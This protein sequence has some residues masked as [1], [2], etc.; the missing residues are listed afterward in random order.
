MNVDGLF[1]CTVVFKDNYESQAKVIVNQGGTSSSKTYSIMQTLILRAIYN[2][3]LVITVTGESIPN[4]KK[5][6]YRD[7]ETIY[8]RSSYMNKQVTAWN[9]TDR[10]IYF[11]SGSIIEFV[12][13]LDEQS[14]KNGKRDLLF[15]NEGQ[16]I[17]W[18]IFFQ[19]AIRTR[20]QIF[21]DY[22]PTVP[23]WVHDKLIG[24][25]PETNDLTAVVQLII[26]DHRH[27]TF[28]SDD[29][30]RKIEGIK[31]KELWRVYARGLT[32]NLTGLIF[33]DWKE[34]PDKDYPWDTEKFGGLDFGYTN[35]PTAGVRIAR[36]GESIYLH[37][38]CYTPGLAPI[39]MKQIFTAEGFTEE[40]NIYCEH[41]PDNIR[42]LRLL[43]IRAIAAR[44]GQGSVNSG[45]IKLKEYKV[46]YTA[47]SKN[48]AE[49]RKRYMW[50]IDKDTGK[51]INTPVDAWNHCLDAAR[52]GVYSHFYRG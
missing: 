27:N 44:K 2:A 41:D 50:D 52:Y 11:K 21:I 3:G 42:Q 35:D 25:S 39:E 26:S 48:L 12:S 24:T 19:L 28:L 16:G 13:N 7:T 23:F 22:N 20:G 46:F 4:L 34:I 30:H 8:A 18:L 29:D 1:E 15:C 40:E 10:I 49:E 45:I 5:G 33:P 51:P 37:E 43:G 32:G 36:V 17:S 14:A 38:L 31:D 9:R 47:S 6:A